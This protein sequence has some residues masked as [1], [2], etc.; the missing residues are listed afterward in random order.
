MSKINENYLSTQTTSLIGL[1]NNLNQIVTGLAKTSLQNLLINSKLKFFLNGNTLPFGWSVAAD[2]G[3]VDIDI[4]GY[5]SVVNFI[6]GK[7]M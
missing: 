6:S 7:L 4:D 2:T 1:K 5:Y 3:S